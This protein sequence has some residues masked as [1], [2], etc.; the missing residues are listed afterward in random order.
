MSSPPR[1]SSTL[2]IARSKC[3]KSRPSSFSTRWMSRFQRRRTLTESWIPKRRSCANWNHPRRST[4]INSN[5]NSTVSRRNG[6]QSTMRTVWLGKTT[7]RKLLN[8]LTGSSIWIKSFNRENLL[9]SRRKRQSI[10]K[11]IVS[12][13]LTSPTK[14][15]KWRSKIF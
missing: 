5:G 13:I 2:Q 10:T 14:I 8:S 3:Y 7:G 1:S 6:R 9:C 15:T 4:S 11:K 12:K